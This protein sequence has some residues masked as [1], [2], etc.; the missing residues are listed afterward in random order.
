MNSF[1]WRKK[2]VK[3][4]VPQGVVDRGSF[5]NCAR[6]CSNHF[7]LLMKKSFSLVILY[8]NYRHKYSMEAVTTV[9]L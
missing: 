8:L 5:V 3:R 2:L 9:F 7:D 6:E 4:D 1:V